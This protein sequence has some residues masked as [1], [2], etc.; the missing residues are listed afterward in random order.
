MFATLIRGFFSGA[1]FSA[2]LFLGANFLRTNF[3]IIVV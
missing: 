2:N 1:F 3:G